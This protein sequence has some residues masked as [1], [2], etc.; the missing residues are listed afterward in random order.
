[1][2]VKADK[3]HAMHVIDSLAVG[4][5]ERMLV[6]IVNNL[7]PEKFTVSVCTTRKSGPLT[8]ELLPRIHYTNLARKYALDPRGFKRIQEF[9]REQQ[10]NIFHA[11]GRSTYSFLLFAK[12]LGFINKPIILHD[13]FGEIESDQSVPIWF[14]Y[15]GA[16]QLS[17]YIGVCEFLGEWAKKASVPVERITSIQNAL[18]LDRFETIRPIDIRAELRIPPTKKICLMLGN[19]RP[20]KGLDLLIETCKLMDKSNMPVFVI[21]G[22]EADQHYTDQ[23][24][25]KISEENLDSFFFLV[26]QQENSIPWI[27]GADFGIIPSRSESGPLVLI[28]Y[29]ACEVPFVAFNVGGV[30]RQVSQLLPNQFATPGNTAQLANILQH[31]QSMDEAD[32]VEF[33]RSIKKIANRMFDINNRLPEIEKIYESIMQETQ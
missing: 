12:I 14:K 30:S 32:K 20:A 16:K 26:G 3:I 9:S 29:M 24:K 17:H 28:E 1:M 8:S 21:V 10:T 22:S 7:N 23:C 27:K 11:H 6:D 31:M 2:I 13:H 15:I 33:S 5:A 4:G 25:Q 19:I 18:D